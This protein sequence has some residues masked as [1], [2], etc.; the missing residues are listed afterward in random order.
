MNDDIQRRLKRLQAT[1]DALLAIV[2][3]GGGSAFLEYSTNTWVAEQGW[4]RTFANIVGLFLF[5]CVAGW[6][7]WRIDKRSN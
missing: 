2:L 5:L 7:Y 3:I 1:V 4:T 6:T